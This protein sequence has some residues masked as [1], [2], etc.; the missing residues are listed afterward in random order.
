MLHDL[1]FALRVLLKN[2]AFTAVV[3]VTMALG[4]GVNTAIFTIV[5]AVLF[6]G[7]PF[8]NPGE[9]AFVSSNRG[10]ISYPDFIDF[11]EQSK[12]FK[13]LG[14][15]IGL[16]ADLSDG[17]T[18]ADRVSGARLTAN[19]F[20]LLGAQPLI[21][22][23]FTVADE[24]LGADPVALLSYG[25]WQS[26]Y[27]GDRDILG[28]TIRINLAE[29]TV[30]GVMRPGEGFPNDTRLWIPLIPDAGP[31]QNRG[32]RAF[33]VFARLGDGVT[34]EQARVELSTLA[35]GLAQAYPDTNKYIEARIAPYTDRGTTGPIRV[36]L[37]S[38]LGAVCFVL[39][40]AC[41]NVANLLLSRAIQR[42]R[43]TSVRT[44]MGA[45]RWRVVRQLLVE[46]V[47]LSLLGGVLGLGV[48]L[49]GVRWIDVAT[50]PTGRP[51]WLD[52]SMDYRVF[53]Y[54]AAVSVLTGILF[55]LAPALQISKSNVS[56][57]LKEG[58]RS[59]IGG[60]RAGRMTDALL[61]GQ[62][63]LTIVL[64]VG[65]GLM[66]R[67]FLIT[68]RFDIG[69]DTQNLVSVQISMQAARYPLPADR[70]AFQE[71]LKERLENLP[72]V[73]SLAIV[74][75]PPA[76]GAAMRTL[77]IEG[78]EMTD[79][80]NRLPSVATIMVAPDYFEALDLAIRRGRGF[81]ESDGAAG[82]EA[83][84]VNETFVTRYFETEEPLGRR[85]RI[86]ADVIRG[87]EDLAA[88]WLT[89]VGVSPPVFQQSPNQDLRVQPTIYLPFRHETPFAFTVLA[90]SGLEGDAVVAGIRNEL[91]QLDP[92]LPLFNI[93]TMDDILAQRNW[94]Y[95]IFGTL[96]ATFAVI[97]LLI[98]SVGIYAVTAH[99]VGQRTQELG[100]R[101]ALGAARRDILWLVFKQGITRI[102]IGMVLGVLAAVGVSRVLASVLVNTTATDPTTF[103]S[104]CLL[105]AVVTLLACFVPARRATRLDPVE[106]LRTE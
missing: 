103:V 48:G 47:M 87:T 65:A 6:K 73:D 98:S 45:S 25:L 77:K 99:G 89:I 7:M 60:K 50:Q 61:V 26:R 76:G 71:R 34:F 31:F 42:T 16:P 69:V 94:P 30:I 81:A 10:G 59:G 84:I 3:V 62:I 58:G 85:I 78:R 72:G 23:D 92:D 68:Q 33:V 80:N 49:A 35:S 55:G 104:I 4:I 54:F 57:N 40:I 46:S 52:F 53:A 91:R 79:S 37:Y 38:L 100:V 24:Q 36:I 18:A 74:S 29:Y 2:R 22:R 75:V 93:R 95:R 88:P 19:T 56:E 44:A 13:G 106:A 51:Y 105:L 101:M 43:E 1:R 8:P 70:L 27:Q 82:A 67:S 39:L 21:G 28:K 11:R 64:L 90:R 41:A 83:V 102:S 96:F 66:I 12:S 9:I 63:G 32:E 5:N 20:S 97:A 14:A 86:G 15:F 17:N